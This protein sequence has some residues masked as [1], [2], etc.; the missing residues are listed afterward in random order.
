MWTD[1][2]TDMRPILLGRL[3]GVDLKT[4][5]YLS[6]TQHFSCCYAHVKKLQYYNH[7]YVLTYLLVVTAVCALLTN[8]RVCVTRNISMMRNGKPKLSR[9]GGVHWTRVH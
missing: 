8:L 9:N 3:F 7:S 4:E 1:V 6:L 5:C 2:R